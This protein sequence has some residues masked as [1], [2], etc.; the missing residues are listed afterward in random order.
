MRPIALGLCCCSLVWL[1]VSPCMLSQTGQTN[2]IHVEP[3][4]SKESIRMSFKP[5]GAVPS[6]LEAANILQDLIA[7][8]GVD[9]QP[10]APWH[11][12]LIYDEFDE[13][14]DNVHSGTIEEFYISP[15]K[16]KKVK[17]TD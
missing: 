14:G 15:K 7:A 2:A 12:E 8:N 16:Y 13:D 9:V 11:V 17:K 3:R 4:D 10:T 6:S 5:S 1:A